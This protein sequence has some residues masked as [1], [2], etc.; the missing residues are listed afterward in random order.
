MGHGPTGMHTLQFV[1]ICFGVHHNIVYN[2]TGKNFTQNWQKQLAHTFTY[3]LTTY[4]R[5]G[6]NLDELPEWALV[7]RL[8]TSDAVK[9]PEC[10]VCLIR[11]QNGDMLLTLPCFHLFHEHCALAWL[12]RV[13]NFLTLYLRYFIHSGLLRV[14]PKRPRGSIDFWLEFS[15]PVILQNVHC[16]SGDERRWLPN[17]IIFGRSEMRSLKS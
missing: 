9:C 17:L 15:E 8:A 11:F 12:C 6:E 3:S 4:F 1:C 5:T 14:T 10:P 13:S 7:T 2:R 16:E